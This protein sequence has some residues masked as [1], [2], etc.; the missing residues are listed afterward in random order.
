[1]EESE[2]MGMRQ[3]SMMLRESREEGDPE[4]QRREEDLHAR[5]MDLGAREQSLR[6]RDE[7]LRRRE[8]NLRE[9]QSRFTGKTGGFGATDYQDYRYRNDR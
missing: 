7:D 9:R 1:M 6:E 2:E 8:Q 5:Q 4:M 3:A